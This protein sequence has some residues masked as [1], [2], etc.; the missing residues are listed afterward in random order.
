MGLVG[1]GGGVERGRIDFICQKIW[2]PVF[3]MYVLGNVKKIFSLLSDHFENN[4]SQM[5]IG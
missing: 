5:V 1:G 3:P 2:L 4:F